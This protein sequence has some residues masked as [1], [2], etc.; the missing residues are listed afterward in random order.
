MLTHSLRLEWLVKKQI[1]HD[2]NRTFEMSSERFQRVHINL[3]GPLSTSYGHIYLLTAIDRY[4]RW[5]EAFPLK[6]IKAK[7][8]VDN[9]IYHWISRYGVLQ[10]I[11]TRELS[12]SS[13]YSFNCPHYS[14]ATKSYHSL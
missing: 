12:S 4:S 5:P 13:N 2:T 8:V 14:L 7:T 1:Y 9:F 11:L 3:V 6:N 10:E